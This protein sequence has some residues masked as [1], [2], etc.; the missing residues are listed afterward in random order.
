MTAPASAPDALPADTDT[1]LHPPQQDR[2]RRTLERMLAAA[3]ALLEAEGADAL[4]ITGIT[5]RAR[6]SVG[7]FY[8]RFDGKEQLLRYLGEAALDEA[9][10]RAR[11]IL[12]GLPSGEL[13]ERVSPAVRDLLELW[14]EGPVRT[15]LLLDGVEDPAPT[16]RSRLE[17]EVAADL[18][19]HLPGPSAR[20]GLGARVLLAVLREA[21]LQSANGASAPLPEP[22]ALAP[23]LTE[24]LVGYLGG[25][26]REP[27]ARLAPAPEAPAAPAADRPP[28]DRA[29]TE[30]R[31]APP[32]EPPAGPRRTEIDPFEVW[33]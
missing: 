26:V 24:L 13:R 1:L 16:R 7:S 19:D 17:D 9:L 10:G 11:E 18:A 28:D 31:P 22:G 14:T 5:R 15:L 20:P 6:T 23:E 21:A 29:P 25:R 3:R 33:E 12:S 8:A 32:K 27:V 30:D 2:S 4:T